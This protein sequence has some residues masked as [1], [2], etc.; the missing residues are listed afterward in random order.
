[1][2]Q[3]TMQKT[4]AALMAQLNSG[5]PLELRACA[6]TVLA[7]S[8]PAQKNAAIAQIERQIAAGQVTLD[9]ARQFNDEPLL[10]QTPGRPQR[11]ELVGALDVPR[12][13]TGSLEGRLGMIHALAHIEFNAINLAL[14]VLVRFANLPDDFY[15]DW[16]RVAC[17]EALHFSLLRA[18]LQRFSS[19]YGAYAAHN[20]LWE[21]AVATQNS[22]ADRMAMVPRTLE[23]RGLDACPLTRE[24]LHQAGDVDG[25]A[26]IDLILRDEIGHVA[27]GN[28]WFV[29][30][31]E[32]DNVAPVL[33]YR[34]IKERLNAPRLRPPFNIKARRAAGFFEEELQEFMLLNTGSHA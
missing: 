2:T 12:R 34:H 17:E 8:E 27:L 16:W 10:L 7:L 19:D 21:M 33:H 3:V 5:A 30:A 9:T 1:M 23:A 32:R 20:G 25:A 18:H 6:L 14:D 15:W 13:K 4:D 22:L 29:Y 24:K 26:I 28:R 31:C 11:P